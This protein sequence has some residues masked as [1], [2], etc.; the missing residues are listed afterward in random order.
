MSVVFCLLGPSGYF[1]VIYGSSSI[2]V[3]LRFMVEI[4]FRR[5]S[6]VILELNKLEIFSELSEAADMVDFYVQV[7]ILKYL[8][9]AFLAKSCCNA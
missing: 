8:L 5:A 2:T 4:L 6:T 7:F 3:S 9:A 1:I